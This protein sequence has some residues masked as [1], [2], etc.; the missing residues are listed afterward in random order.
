MPSTAASDEALQAAE[1]LLSDEC[2]PELSN[3]E[4]DWLKHNIARL[5]DWFAAETPT[6]EFDRL[7]RE[8]AEY[9]EGIFA[10]HRC[11]RCNHGE[12]ACVQFDPHRCD[13]PRALND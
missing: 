2:A 13:Y 5:C 9:R 10:T 3:G 7:L 6:E 12:K 1:E 8:A 11:W 4:H